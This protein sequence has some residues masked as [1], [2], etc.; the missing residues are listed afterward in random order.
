MPLTPKN[1]KEEW[2]QG[3]VDHETTLT[4]KNRPEEWMLGL[5]EGSTTLT[6]KNRCEEWMKEIIDASGG[7]GTGFSI[8]TGSF[9]TPASA[10]NSDVEIPYSGEG[11][12]LFAAVFVKGGINNNTEGGNQTWYSLIKRQAVGAWYMSKSEMNTTPTYLASGSKNYGACSGVYKSSATNPATYQ[13]SASAIVPVFSNAAAN[14]GTEAHTCVKFKGGPAL[15]TIYTGP[16][17]QNY[18]YGLA[19]DTEYEYI[20]LYSE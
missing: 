6:P 20:I 16:D 4:P 7:G 13:S 8:V 14:P 11:Y 2:L 9:T 12:P 17:L 3:L 1:R 15:L 18:K 5:V 10:G 19:E